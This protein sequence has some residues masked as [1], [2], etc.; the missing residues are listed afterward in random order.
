MFELFAR[1]WAVPAPALG[2]MFNASQS[3]AA[4]P[5]GD[6]SIALVACADAE[7]P[8]SRIAVDASGRRTIAPRRSAPRAASIVAASG[9]GPAQIVSGSD[10]EFLIAWNDAESVASRPGRDGDP[11]GGAAGFGVAGRAR[12][13]RRN[14]DD[15]NERRGGVAA[16]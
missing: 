9:P 13:S 11:G 5:L 16:G 12:P 2:L 4:A 7:P 6:G 15:L 14:D 3:Q 10:D 1:R 8:E